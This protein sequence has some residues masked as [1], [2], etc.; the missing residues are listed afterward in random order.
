MA[1]NTNWLNIT[2]MSGGTGETSLSLTALTNSSLSAKTATI[3]AKNTTYNVQ[4][5]TTVTIQGFV[6]TLTLSR[7]TLRFDSTGGTATFT[8]YSNTSWTITYPA[9]VHSY[10][11]SAGTG[12][13]EVTVVL[14]PNPDEVAKIDTGIVKDTYNINQL[15]LTIVQ[16]S[17][18]VELS[19]EPDDDITFDNTGSSTYVVIDC[20]T[21]WDMEYPSWVTP[22]VISGTSGTT[23]VTFTAGENG[24]NDRSGTV[25]IYA[26][27]KSVEINVFQPFYIPPYI[28][29]T[30]SAWTFNYT[31]DGKTFI[32]DSYPEWTGEIVSTGET[33]WASDTYMEAVFE[34]PSS[35]TIQLYNSYS[36]STTA[37]FI[38]PVR[39]YTSSYVTPSSGTY[40]VRYE[41]SSGGT[42]PAITNNQYLKEVHL[43]DKVG[44]IRS[45]GFTGCSALSSVT[46]GTGLTTVGSAAFSGCSSLASI[47]VAAPVAP[48]VCGDTFY[49]VATGG[50]LAYPGGSNYNSWLSPAA[51]LLGYYG[52]PGFSGKTYMLLEYNVTSTSENTKICNDTSYFSAITFE[53]GESVPLGTGYTFSETGRNKLRFYPNTG[54]LSGSCF[55]GCNALV[56]V[57][58]SDITTIVGG[59]SFNAC[60]SLSSVTLNNSLQVLG[61][62]IHCSSLTTLTIPSSVKTI[63]CLSGNP[64]EGIIIPNGVTTL[65]ELCFAEC[66]NL[67]SLRIPNSV[68]SMGPALMFN[69]SSLSSFT[70][71]DRYVGPLSTKPYYGFGF[72]EG[73]RSLLRIELPEGTTIVDGD[74]FENCT[75]LRSIIFPASVRRISDYFIK[76]CV[77]LES[78]IFYG[79]TAPLRQNGNLDSL[80]FAYLNHYEGVL[81]HPAGANYNNYFTTGKYGWSLGSWRWTEDTT[82]NI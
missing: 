5:T 58:L 20:N 27:S 41:M 69:C 65:G 67:R 16:E 36:G 22:S 1:N 13:T 28:T 37:I 64:F 60:S 73:C 61:G 55:S 63:E 80:A 17:F 24:P 40:I 47:S 46:I 33:V 11:T 21:D 81:Y 6:P 14:A 15:Y 74:C 50:T 71:Q 23:T 12:D 34:V 9:L 57:E 31:E 79:T 44:V 76:N 26:G 42:T 19:V 30:P 62:F 3:T 72:F 56:G 39:H 32:V 68:T 18:I 38:G 59:N 53:N 66:S 43:T 45:S 70:F 4:D 52:W 77:S 25:I 29:V 48:S 8:V 49:G 51:Y 10:S 54:T 82:D 2:P 7:S 35:T 78:L 75:N